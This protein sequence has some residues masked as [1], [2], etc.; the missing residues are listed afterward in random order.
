MNNCSSS[1]YIII[2]IVIIIISYKWYL[3][4]LLRSLDRCLQLFLRFLL[5][6]AF[7]YCSI[8]N[9]QAGKSFKFAKQVAQ[10]RQV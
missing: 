2:I 10:T 1:I 6:S 7:V 3:Y 9:I 8:Q 4:Q 5:K